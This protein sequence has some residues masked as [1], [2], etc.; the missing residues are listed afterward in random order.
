MLK[1]RHLGFVLVIFILHFSTA[2]AQSVTNKNEVSN[3]M[4]ITAS[5]SSGHVRFTAPVSIV[6][7]RLEVYGQNGEKLFDNE[8]RGGN[9]I[10]WLL[11]NGQAERLP[12]GSYLCVVTVKTL[13]GKLSQRLAKLNIEENSAGFKA[14]DFSQLTAQQAHSVGPIEESDGALMI[15]APNDSQPAT[16]IAHNGEDGQLTRH[17]G[18]LSFRLGDFF[19]GK[20][21]EQMRLTA[22]GNL[23]IGTSQPQV[24]LDVN[25]RIRASEGLVFPDGSVQFSASRK[26]LGAA[27]QRPGQS[28]HS[29]R[30]NGMLT[31]DISGTGTTGK[32]SKWLDGPNG[33]LNDSN[34]TEVSG[35]I[36]INGTPNTAFRLDVN[37][38]TRIR[39]S[40][41]GFNLEGLRAA[42][43]IWLFQTVDDDGRFRLFSQDN[44]NPGQERLTISLSTGN[45]GI[46]VTAPSQK[47]HVGGNGLFTGNLTVN[48]TLNATLPTGSANYIQNTT[49][50]QPSSNFNISGNGTVG[51]TLSGNIVNATTQ[52]NI[53]SAHILSVLGSDSL[54]AGF[55]AGENT[56]G[57]GNSFFGSFAGQLNT[58]GFGNAFFGSNAGTENTT[59]SRNS[60]FGDE[61]G[62]LSSTGSDN[63]LFGYRAGN[64]NFTGQD[65]SIFGS[66]AGESTKGNSNS[67]FGKSAGGNNFTGTSNSFFGSFAGSSN[68]TENNNTFIGFSSDGQAGITNATAIG[69]RAKVTGSNSLVLGSIN[70]VNGA[71]ADTAVGIGTTVPTA[72]LHVHGVVKFDVLAT[73]VGTTLCRNVANQ[74]TDCGASS[75]KYKTNVQPFADG[76]GVVN[77]LR[78]VTFNWKEGG[79]LD[80]GFIAEEMEKV[81][82]LLVIHSPEGEVHGVRY[83]R[84]NVVLVNAI[85]EQQA[86][87]EA[88]QKEIAALK[89]LICLDHPSAGACKP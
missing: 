66:F 31:P 15:F 68:T 22:E 26:T 32:I 62:N 78:P 23:G 8:L 81:E 56:T 54:F 52:F 74:I 55:G 63:S 9:V 88:Q 25:G 5:A 42:G 4:I 64:A 14:T 21:S 6:Q 58:T 79:E 69:F 73:G 33:V 71:T 87:I 30:E 20:D 10:D 40:N 57:I 1:M 39:G 36:G 75:L 16:V 2:K 51:G 46:G 29:Q 24:R 89:K 72:L 84:I 38:S 67:F 82:P 47:L 80:F 27:S 48:G 70:G 61:A 86:Q 19:S 3:S 7:I 18:A 13:T 49:T 53:G 17:K 45:V 41:P 11:Q 35:A 50:Q 28:Q 85:K 44:V 37:G 43:N 60:F 59:G 34:I 12:S 65:N 83:D 77:R 76:L